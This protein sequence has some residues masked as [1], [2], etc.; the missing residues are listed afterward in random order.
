MTPRAAAEILNRS[1]Q[2]IRNLVKDGKA[3]GTEALTEHGE[4]RY[5]IAQ[6]AVA[7]MLGEDPPEPD[8]QPPSDATDE[9]N[10]LIDRVALAERYLDAMEDH[11]K[12]LVN[13][14]TEMRTH[15]VQT[16][17]RLAQLH[18]SA[19]AAYQR[20]LRMILKWLVFA[21]VISALLDALIHYIHL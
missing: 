17:E 18:E 8:W 3:D 20:S 21:I 7:D 1:D 15:A 10:R 2:T 16:N 13:I 14:L 19:Q 12:A 11:N 9:D 4:R 5:Y 6:E